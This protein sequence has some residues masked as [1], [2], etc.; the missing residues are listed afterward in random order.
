MHDYKQHYGNLTP[1]AHAALAY[2][3]M[4]FLA[5]AI[6]RAGTTGGEKL[7]DALAQTR[8]FSGVTGFISMDSERNAV[9]AAVILK[10]Q[11]GK[12]I[13]QE[14]IQPEAP[15]IAAKASPSASPTPKR[16][17]RK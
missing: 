1:D 9:K 10:L 6:E 17:R 3:A 11:D 7:R 13:Y 16:S 12:Y 5:E 4:R 15:D 14:T 2:D 8:D